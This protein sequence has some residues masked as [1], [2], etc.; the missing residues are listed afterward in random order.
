MRARHPDSKGPFTWLVDYNL[1]TF[2][3]RLRRLVTWLDEHT[4]PY[5]FRHTAC[6]RWA[7]DRNLA[8][9]GVTLA[10]IA[11][12]A[13]H[14]IAMQ[15]RYVHAVEEADDYASLVDVMTGNVVPIRPPEFRRPSDDMGLAVSQ[16]M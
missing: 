13:G 2:W 5:S 11:Q 12:W 10:Q 16:S 4:V 6:T 3:A 14:S 7:N 15:Q 8:L 9:R 1:H